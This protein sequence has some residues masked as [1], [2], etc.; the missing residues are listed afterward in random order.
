MNDIFDLNTLSR[1]IP[2]GCVSIEAVLNQSKNRCIGEKDVKDINN[3]IL[4]M[5]LNYP[6]LY[7]MKFSDMVVPVPVCSYVTPEPVNRNRYSN[8]SNV[9][10][11]S[12]IS[13]IEP[14]LRRGLISSND[15]TLSLSPPSTSR[16]SRR[17]VIK[18]SR[19]SS[20]P[21]LKPEVLI[22]SGTSS[23]RSLSN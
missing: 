7:S 5:K 10:N 9:S 4:Y 2:G 8:V 23:R 3:A 6:D 15:E 13:Y 17:D 21:S 18:S 1:K 20:I 22:S 19:V 11:V 12:N 14:T 16:L